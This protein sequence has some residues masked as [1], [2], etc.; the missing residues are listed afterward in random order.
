L[1]RCGDF[2]GWIC[3]GWKTGKETQAG[4]RLRGN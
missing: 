3:R 4:V 1:G 2:H